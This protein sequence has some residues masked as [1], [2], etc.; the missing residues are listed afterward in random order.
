M[1][2]NIGKYIDVEQ[3]EEKILMVFPS[4]ITENKKETTNTLELSVAL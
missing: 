1:D 4:L 2:V 3:E